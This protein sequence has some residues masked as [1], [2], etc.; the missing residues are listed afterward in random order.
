MGKPDFTTSHFCRDEWASLFIYFLQQKVL[1]IDKPRVFLIW[2]RIVPSPMQITL[3]N[4]QWP[5]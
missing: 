3:T 4:T 5:C 1:G 2:L